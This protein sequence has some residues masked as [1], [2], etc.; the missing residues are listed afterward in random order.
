MHLFIFYCFLD[1]LDEYV[2]QLA[3]APVTADSNVVDGPEFTVKVFLS[4]T[5]KYQIRIIHINPGKPTGNAFIKSFQGKFRDGRLNLHRFTSLINARDKI[6]TWRQEH[7]TERPH[8]FP[9]NF[10]PHEFM[11]RIVLTG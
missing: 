5:E 4:W 9:G 3:V 2:V 7:D 11:E 10:T 6:E 8:R 1:T